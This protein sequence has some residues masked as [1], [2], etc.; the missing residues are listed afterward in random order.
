[1]EVD[2]GVGSSTAPTVPDSSLPPA[3]IPRANPENQILAGTTSPAVDV[4]PSMDERVTTKF[5]EQ[6]PV[7]AIKDQAD[8][9]LVSSVLEAI[10]DERKLRGLDLFCGGGNFGRGVGDGGAV[11]HKWCV[12][13]NVL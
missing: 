12:L 4:T 7:P 11:Q 10:P 2:D 8:N 9:D 3:S 1:M 5:F 6:T 13:T